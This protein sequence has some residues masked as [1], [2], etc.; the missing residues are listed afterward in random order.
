MSLQCECLDCGRIDTLLAPVVDSSDL[1][2]I[3]QGVERAE[4]RA[5]EKPCPECGGFNFGPLHR[6]EEPSARVARKMAEL[7]G[8]PPC[9]KCGFGH[10]KSA[11]GKCIIPLSSERLAAL[12]LLQP[13]D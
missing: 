3:V 12:G 5:A 7:A 1:A 10:R 6:I 4:E 11:P 9:E 8:D 13:D 2:A